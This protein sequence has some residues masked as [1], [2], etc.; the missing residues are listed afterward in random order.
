MGNGSVNT[1]DVQVAS[2][3]PA[4]STLPGSKYMSKEG[5]H[6]G[7]FS[8]LFISQARSRGENKGK[9]RCQLLIISATVVLSPGSSMPIDVVCFVLGVLF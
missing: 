1:N 4:H 2:P 9:K 7:F 5:A 8:F 3:A 6:L